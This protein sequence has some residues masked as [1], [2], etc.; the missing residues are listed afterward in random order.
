MS[1]INKAQTRVP[2]RV[3]AM[4]L[5]PPGASK[6]LFLANPYSSKSN[7][8]RRQIQPESFH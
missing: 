3:V 2:Y 7:R 1:Y 5:V 6:D 8:H 4:K